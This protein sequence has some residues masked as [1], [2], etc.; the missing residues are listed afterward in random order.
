M[1]D[2]QNI[3]VICDDKEKRSIFVKKF[4]IRTCKNIQNILLVSYSN[5]VKKL[6]LYDFIS[7]ERC[8]DKITFYNDLVDRKRMCI[9]NKSRNH[10][11]SIIIDSC[12]KIKNNNEEISNIRKLLFNGR[13]IDVFPLILTADNICVLTPEKRVNL[14]KIIILDNLHR[15]EKLKIYDFYIPNNIPFDDFDDIFTSIINKYGCVVIDC[16][17][18]TNSLEDIVYFSD[19]ID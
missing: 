18:S 16:N 10:Y 5:K 1:N 2:Y 13:H 17:G 12:Q 3:C 15:Y 6:N 8:F 14:T 9:K 11:T 4:L 7:K 19:L